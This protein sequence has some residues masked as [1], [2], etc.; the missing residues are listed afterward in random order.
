MIHHEL[1]GVQHGPE[2]FAD[3]V[4]RR[5]CGTDIR[6]RLR[7]LRRR[8]ET[9]H[10]AEKDILDRA[11]E[12]HG[13]AEL[14]TREFRLRAGDAYVEFADLAVVFLAFLFREQLRAV[15]LGTL[16][17][18]ALAAGFK[19]RQLRAQFLRR[20]FRARVAAK[21]LD[22]SRAVA[23]RRVEQAHQRGIVA[24]VDRLEQRWIAGA[25][26]VA[27]RE[28]RGFAESG[29]RVAVA[30][31]RLATDA[32]VRSDRAVVE[33]GQKLRLRALGRR[34]HRQRIEDDLRGQTADQRVAEI[35]LIELVA[36]RSLPTPLIRVAAR[37]LA[38]Q[39]LHVEATLHKARREIV[40]QLLVRRRIREV[41]VIRRLDDAASE[42]HGPHPVHPR[43]GEIRIL[44]RAKPIHERTARIGILR[45][46]H[47]AAAENLRREDAPVERRVLLLDARD[48]LFTQRTLILHRLQIDLLP[49]HDLAR[50]EQRLQL[51]AILVAV[52]LRLPVK[53]RLFLQLLRDAV[54]AHRVILHT[55]RPV[56][57]RLEERLELLEV[58]LR[59]LVERMLV[60]LG[61]L[62]AHAE[63]SVRKRERLLLRLAHIL[64]LPEIRHR[65]ALR[66]V[67]AV[68]F[69][70]IGS[71]LLRKFLVALIRA[72]APGAQHDPRDHLIVR[73][74]FR[75]ALVNPIIP[76]P[77]KT[78]VELQLAAG[79]E[80]PRI[81]AGVVAQQRRPPRR[82]A[83][84]LQQLLD[85]LRAFVRRFV[86]EKCTHRLRRRRRGREVEARAPQEFRICAN[87][88]RLDARLAQLCEHQ[89]VHFRPRLHRREFRSDPAG[90][91][92]HREN[93]GHRL[94][95][96]VVKG[97]DVRVALALRRH[98][99]RVIHRGDGLVI[100]AEARELRD[101]LDR[102]VF[103]AC[104]HLHL[105]HIAG[106]LENDLLRRH[107]EQRKLARLRHVALRATLDP[108]QDQ[109]VFPRSLVE[110][111]L[112]LVL[113]AVERRLR[114]DEAPHRL[115]QIHAHLLRPALALCDRLMVLFKIVAKK[116]KLEST[117]PLER[118]V[119][120]TP[121]APRTRHQRNHMPA[122]TRVV[123]LL[124][125]LPALARG[126][127]DMRGSR[128]LRLLRRR[129][130]LADCVGNDDGRKQTEQ[131]EGS[132]H[133]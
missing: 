21:L 50:A 82:V 114:E 83:G 92:A 98:E 33:V 57:H 108:A 103:P 119:T 59:P 117:A 38:V 115:L 72:R 125:I 101:V 88:R 132:F 18:H 100:R 78:V 97:D 8:R 87:L 122:E 39:P 109:I 14:R 37:D 104:E 15:A 25:L 90:E 130:S 32:R 46:R 19:F 45:E 22:P 111:L 71:H 76:L 96:V 85:F 40:H 24:D 48:V 66:E 20:E 9:R 80:L 10:S 30:T 73:R 34:G 95:A 131:Q 118:P 3:A 41:H 129:L 12:I 116:R 93:R 44:L 128:S 126:F 70:K 123:R 35:F 49:R 124:N 79:V 106:F 110:A 42:I 56:I 11:V 54:V 65:L 62:D 4:H 53:A 84:R 58:R 133:E 77:R 121:A 43:A 2:Q 7:D 69:A 68:L 17:H 74:V 102:A 16:L 61:A 112:P 47:L 64:P 89:F 120:L 86:R 105:D 107:I 5:G 113:L 99:T 94:H 67:R 1:A 127:R 81:V 6:L 55:P 13:L 26:T 63:E 31:L 23:L 52:P 29:E 51:L 28:A 36:R 75:D 91:I 27:V 60:A